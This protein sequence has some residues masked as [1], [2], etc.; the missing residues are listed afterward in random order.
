[1]SPDE[2]IERTQWDTFWVPD[3]VTVRDDPGLLMMS[4]P[5]HPRSNYNM[6][7][8]LRPH[9][10][11]AQLVERV[12]G[13]HP[14]CI[15]IVPLN[16][17]NHTPALE[18]E[19]RRHGYEPQKEYDAYLIRCDDYSPRAHEGVQ[20]RLVTTMEELLA[21]NRVNGA[22]FDTEH[23]RTPE[24]LEQFLRDGLGPRVRRAVAWRGDE[25]L[26]AG[27]VT[28]HPAADIAFLWGGGTVPHARH[29]G[30]YSAVM[31]ARIAWAR[32]VGLTWVGLYA[33][34]GTSGPVVAKQGFTRHGFMTFWIRTP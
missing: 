16:P 29:V 8:R 17:L 31:E 6:V 27:G 22:A 18:R 34:R 28:A 33:R 25:P 32:S 5:T 20:G 1:M 3:H 21:F 15:S 14:D 13:R 30:A 26:S 24:E 7:L 2:R 19:L 4:C 12:V 10:R 9:G 23:E 11:E